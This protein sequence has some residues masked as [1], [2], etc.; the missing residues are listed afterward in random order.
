MAVGESAIQTVQAIML[1]ISCACWNT[2]GLVV[3]SQNTCALKAVMHPIS[4]TNAHSPCRRLLLQAMLRVTRRPML[5]VTHQHRLLPIPLATMAAMDVT[6]DL[7]ASV[8]LWTAQTIGHVVAT[9]QQGMS[10]QLDVI[11]LTVYIHVN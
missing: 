8:T 10:A 7:V 6:L 9:Q 5:L 3:A 11:V 1:I 4:I 2:A